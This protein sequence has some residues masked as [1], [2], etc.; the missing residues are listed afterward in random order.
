MHSSQCILCILELQRGRD[1]WEGMIYDECFV[2]VSRIHEN[3]CISVSSGLLNPL[4][5]PKSS[6]H[7]FLFF[8]RLMEAMHC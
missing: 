1:A 4:P 3:V 5:V 8:G 2:G 7:I 6:L